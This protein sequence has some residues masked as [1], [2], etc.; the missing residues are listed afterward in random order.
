MLKD[1]KGTFDSITN[2]RISDF[3]NR[4][5]SF[6]ERIQ[7]IEDIVIGLQRRIGEPHENASE[8]A[9]GEKIPNPPENLPDFPQEPII[10]S[11][12]PII[13]SKVKCPSCG[14]SLQRKFIKSGEHF[15]CFKSKNGCGKIYVRGVDRELIG[16]EKTAT[17]SYI[18]R[19]GTK[20]KPQGKEESYQKYSCNPSTK[21]GCGKGYIQ[22]KEGNLHLGR[23]KK[24]LERPIVISNPTVS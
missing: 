21:G 23:S 19:C 2:R 14:K 13:D 8:K 16:K 18:C 4:Y 15:Y 7:E 10:D 12:K 5:K 1:A 17:P 22:D 20:L 11:K 9:K 24:A 6:D 3:T